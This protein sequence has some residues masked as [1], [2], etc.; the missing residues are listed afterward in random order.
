MA[1]NAALP[2][3]LARVG[4]A[5]SPYVAAGAGFVVAAAFAS[6]GDIGLVASVTVFAVYVIFLAV[7]IALIRLRFSSPGTERPFRTPL[8]VGRVPLLPIG[9]IATVIVMMAFLTPAAWLLGSGAA[10][11]GGIAWLL[12][13]GARERA[14][15]EH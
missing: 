14:L 15:A 11:L 4:R 1:R 13:A 8:A 2:P 12:S 7:N 10:V 3:V 9:G 6:M 5:H